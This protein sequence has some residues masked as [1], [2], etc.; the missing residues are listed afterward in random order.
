MQDNVSSP[1]YVV[2][3]P[4][5]LNK[6]LFFKRAEEIIDS[7]KWGNNGRYVLELEEYIKEYLGC[8]HV[9]AVSNASIA[10]E[11]ALEEIKRRLAY[12]NRRLTCLVPSFTFVSTISAIKRAGIDIKYTDIDDYYCISEKDI[13]NKSWD[14][15]LPVNLFGNLPCKEAYQYWYTTVVDAAH[16]LGVYHESAGAYVGADTNISAFS[17]H[18]TK[19]GGSGECGFITCED[20]AT[21][22]Y[23]RQLR[24]FGYDTNSGKREGN[25]VSV[26]TNAKISEMQAALALT[27][28]ESLQEIQNHYYEVYQEYK[29]CLDGL[30]IFKEKNNYFSNYSYIVLEVDPLK[31]D[32]IV[33]ELAID[34]IFARTYFTPVHTFEPYKQDVD[35]P[36][37]ERVAKSIICMPTGLTVQKKD[38]QFIC[39]TLRRLINGS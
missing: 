20:S 33:D 29:R 15:I 27:Q 26:G 6:E 2:G 38:V 32:R 28:L 11:F 18:S 7:H 12:K 21:A 1:N 37:T 5:L 24:N 3:R 39:T 36:N 35:L 31:R 4:Y 14:F 10:I 9:I 34:N 30:G 13:L 23:M 17:L 25:V 8:N 22:E 19:I 16:S